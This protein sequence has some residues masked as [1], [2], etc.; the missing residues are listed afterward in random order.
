MCGICGVFVAQGGAS[1]SEA[2]LINMRDSL[3][4]RGPDAAGL[5]IDASRRLGL[6]HRRLSIVDLDDASTQPMSDAGQSVVVVFNGEI[7]N[8]MALRRELEVA[9]YRF[10][11]A[12]SDTEVLVHGY[13]AW[14]WE[15]LLQRLRGMFAI[16]LWDTLRRVLYLGRD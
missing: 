3:S 11:T 7:Y 14:G 5:W 16:A 6:G 12:H 15:G 4:H 2:L 9:G 10:R 13:R 1:V 8:H